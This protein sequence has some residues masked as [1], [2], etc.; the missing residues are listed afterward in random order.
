[1]APKLCAG[2]EPLAVR[3][4]CRACKYMAVLSTVPRFVF[5]SLGWPDAT[6]AVL[7]AAKVNETAQDPPNADDKESTFSS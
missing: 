1:M 3:V 5:R 6:I 2:L 4:C 7:S